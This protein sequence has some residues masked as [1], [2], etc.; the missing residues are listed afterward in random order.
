MKDEKTYEEINKKIEEGNAVVLTKEEFLKIV[1]EKGIKIAAKEVDVVTTGT[2]GPMC[3][4]GAFLNFGH[5]KPR[6]KMGGGTVLLN[7]VPVYTGIAAVDTYVGATAVPVND[8]TNMIFPGEF[9]YGGGHVIHDL[10]AGK[11]VLLEAK[12]YGTNCYPRKTLETWINIKDINEAILCNPRNA[13][14]NYNCAVNPSN[15]T[16]Y[17]YMGVLK[18]NLGNANYCSAAQLSPLLNDPLYK[19]IGI[20]TRIFLGGGIGYVYW[21]GT[22]HNP[23]VTRG[24]NGVPRGGAGTLA[25]VGDLKQMS[26]DWLIGVSFLGYG[27]TLAVGIGIPIPILNEDIAKFVYVKDEDIFAQVVDYSES[28]P[29]F[30]PGSLCEVNYKELKS[31][32]VTIRGKKV[33]TSSLS[34]YPKARKITQLLKKM[35]DNKKFMLGKAVQLLPSAGSDYTC[36]PLKER[37]VNKR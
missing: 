36:K 32:E 24:P 8:P 33:P 16:I 17:T 1:E 2:F 19:T 26:P 13:Y 20:G 22:Q 27:A 35:I 18:P 10:V 29:Q 11:D 7:G 9:K 4:S 15:K 28:Y 12:A 21:N 31:G 3:S 34:S 23:N 37:P 30:V 14:Q 5:T 6:M 25:V